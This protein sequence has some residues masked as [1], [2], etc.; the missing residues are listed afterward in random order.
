VKIRKGAQPPALSPYR[1]PNAAR[2]VAAAPPLHNH[3]PIAPRGFRPANADELSW[4]AALAYS[5]PGTVAIELV[6]RGF[7]EVRPL[8]QWL[9]G[10]QGV[11]A[12]KDR[13]A[14]IAFRGSESTLDWVLDCLLVPWGRPPRHLGFLCAWWSV[15]ARARAYLEEHRGHFDIIELCGHSLGGAVAK[16]AALE[17]ASNYRID[18]VVTLGCPR[19]FWGGGVRKYDEALTADGQR[20]GERTLSYVHGLDVVAMMPPALLGYRHT[21][22]TQ[23][24]SATGAGVGWLADLIQRIK[25]RQGSMPPLVPW[26]PP[27]AARSN[28]EW[29]DRGSAL[30]DRLANAYC[31][32]E[33]NGP[34]PKPLLLWL[35][36]PLGL[37]IAY[38]WL[39]WLFA[40]A[41]L[42][43]RLAPYLTEVFGASLERRPLPKAP[44]AA[45]IGGWI[46]ALPLLALGMLGARALL[47]SIG[48]FLWW[49]YETTVGVWRQ[50]N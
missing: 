44:A 47:I 8:S 10:T 37:F 40:S 38:L 15:R 31:W 16:V 34:I 21:S 39:L 36:A 49:A 20:L 1:P 19:V 2:P 18:A 41:S 6:A 3:A 11:L 45:R 46:A 22:G 26:T 42:S 13:R 14:V 9:T 12:L 29:H 7:A 35:L 23:P 5:P 24:T 32:I 33:E 48:T 43:H 25:R 17:L 4:L 27:P 28:V 50:L 30:R